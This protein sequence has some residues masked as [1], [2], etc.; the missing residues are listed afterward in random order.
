MS[1]Q[2]PLPL[3]PAQD[4]S[5]DAFVVGPGNRDA[6]DFLDLWPNWP[7]PSVA[8]YG[9][10]GSGKTHLARIWAAETGAGIISAARLGEAEIDEIPYV[11]ENVDI[12][13]L[14][15]AGEQILFALIERGAPLLITGREPPLVWPVRLPD[16]A[17]RTRAL[18]GFP[19]WAPD[20]EWLGELAKKLFAFRQL[21]VPDSVAVA[22]VKSLERSPAA[23]CAFVARADSEALA[24]HRPVSLSLVK[25]L[26]ANEA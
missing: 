9:P 6:V 5:R 4:F 2:L 16:L 20:D 26:L 11:V 3:E 14:S 17:S 15:D 10:A 1:N 22:M 21:V 19:L 23:I 18:L 24:R 25:D 7:A 12:E 8:I 13:P